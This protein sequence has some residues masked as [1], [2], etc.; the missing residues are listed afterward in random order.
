MGSLTNDTI[1]GCLNIIGVSPS[2]DNLSDLHLIQEVKPEMDENMR[3]CGDMNGNTFII[4]L[5]VWNM[6]FMTFHSVGK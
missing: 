2:I 5:V 3:Q 1:V 6:F 4:W